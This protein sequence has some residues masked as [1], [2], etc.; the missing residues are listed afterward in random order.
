MVSDAPW[1]CSCFD[2]RWWQPVAASTDDCSCYTEEPFDAGRSWQRPQVRYHGIWSQIAK[3]WIVSPKV[4]NRIKSHIA[5]IQIESLM[6]K[7]NPVRRFNRDLNR[8][9]TGICPLLQH[10]HVI[11][12]WSSSASWCRFMKFHR[13]ITNPKNRERSKFKMAAAATLKIAF[14]VIFS[15]YGL[16]LHKIFHGD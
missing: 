3:R 16:Y 10:S 4:P 7:S 1:S 13:N 5:V 11:L 14:M 12:T 15:C 8:I 9:T 2:S 6:V